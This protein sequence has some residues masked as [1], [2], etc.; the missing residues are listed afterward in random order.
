[1]K[2]TFQVLQGRTAGGDVGIEEGLAADAGDDGITVCAL[3]I[4]GEG[5]RSEEGLLVGGTG[6]PAPLAGG[7]LGCRSFRFEEKACGRESI[8]AIG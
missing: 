8:T 7:S 1:M 2:F 3:S 6:S 4:A 5:E